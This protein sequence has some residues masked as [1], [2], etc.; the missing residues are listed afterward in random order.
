[1][2]GKLGFVNHARPPFSAR[3]AA[4]DL[5]PPPFPTWIKPADALANA[6]WWLGVQQSPQLWRAIVYNLFIFYRL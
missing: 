4:L 2:T 3:E 1:M 6:A 5:P